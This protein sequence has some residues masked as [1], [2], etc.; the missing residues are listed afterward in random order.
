MFN[1]VKQF[2]KP[3]INS[4]IQSAEQRELED[5]KTYI[6]CFES[7]EDYIHNANNIPRIKQEPS[8]TALIPQQLEQ[9]EIIEIP[10]HP[11]CSTC[12]KLAGKEPY[13][14]CK[15]HKPGSDNNGN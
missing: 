10:K 7:E 8:L 6:D 2:W 13:Y 11:R 9:E 12:N 14:F 15:L 1:C 3:K 5:F 4:T